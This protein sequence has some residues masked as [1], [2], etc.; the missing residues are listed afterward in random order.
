M[1]DNLRNLGVD[2]LDVVNLRVMGDVHSPTEGSI[3]EQFS[4]LA[5]LQRKE[6]IRDLG[7]SNVTL[8]PGGGGATHC[9]GRLRA[10]LLQSRASP[11]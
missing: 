9:S 11:R 4:T 5:E 3:E 2:A 10:E 6:L 7:L 1:E 8:P